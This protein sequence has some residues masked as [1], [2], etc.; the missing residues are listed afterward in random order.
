MGFTLPGNGKLPASSL[1]PAETHPIPFLASLQTRSTLVYFRR[2]RPDGSSSGRATRLATGDS[3]SRA[4]K[5]KSETLRLAPAHHNPPTR[6]P[7][8]NHSTNLLPPRRPLVMV[9]T[10]QGTPRNPCHS[11]AQANQ[12]PGPAE[13]RRLA[14]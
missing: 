3:A 8:L 4:E 7:A 1:Q 13:D 9:L 14:K 6:T 12:D 11:R 2:K 10:G 5:Q